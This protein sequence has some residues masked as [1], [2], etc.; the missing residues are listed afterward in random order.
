MDYANR[1]KK[2]RAELKREFF[3]Q[4]PSL[5][6]EKR[7]PVNSRPIIDMTGDN[8]S[9]DS[10]PVSTRKRLISRNISNGFHSTEALKLNHHQKVVTP[11]QSRMQA[12]IPKSG[13]KPTATNLTPVVGKFSP[14]KYIADTVFVN[15][16]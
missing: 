7:T 8:S 3:L 15:I 2:T 11:T 9:D 1:D 16:D 6:F 13:S 10:P 5:A 4:G 12:R 14:R